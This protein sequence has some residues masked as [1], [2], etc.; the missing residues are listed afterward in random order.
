VER[1]YLS[2]PR[3]ESIVPIV[4]RPDTISIRLKEIATTS[5]LSAFITDREFARILLGAPTIYLALP[6]VSAHWAFVRAWAEPHYL[7][8]YGLTPAGTVIV[9]TP[10]DAEEL[11]VCYSLF[12]ESYHF[13]VQFVGREEETVDEVAS[14]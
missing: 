4:G 2:W 1:N 3:I 10:I 7:G 13:C 14:S 12:Y 5:D 9:Y 8:S 11:D 6:F